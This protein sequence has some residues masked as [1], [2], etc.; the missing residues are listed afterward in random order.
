VS[1]FEFLRNIT[2]GQR[3]PVESTWQRLDPRTR[4]LALSF[5]VIAVTFSTHPVGLLLGVAL[6]LAG[7]AFA[8]IPLRFA[9][10]GLI[11]PLPFL[12]ILALLQV[13][14]NPLPK[15]LVLLQIG[16]VSIA[17]SDLWAGAALLL[18]FI[19]LILIL[20]LGTFT[21]ST[22]EMT[23]ALSRLLHPLTR[24][25]L[26][27]QD[28]VMMVQVTLRFLPLLAQTAERIAK[29]QA[30]RGA[31]WGVRRGSLLARARQI[32]PLIVPLFLMSLHR[33]ENMALAMDARAYGAQAV[34]TSMFSLHFR[35]RDMLA[36][37]TAA[38][39][40]AAVLLL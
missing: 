10:R 35:R 40:A 12:L 26:P 39:L 2:I 1:E 5:L 31:E 6:A 4:L 11:P 15:T 8:R 18:R 34:R 23:R 7:L 27:V 33:A 21:L 25:G 16:T 30:A 36:L 24:I 38:A 3:L 28:F 17:L 20:S 19:A 37:L 32:L 14:I 29:A 9:L 22:S 13:F